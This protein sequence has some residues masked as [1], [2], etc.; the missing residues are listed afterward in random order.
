VLGE[1]AALA[2]GRATESDGGRLEL[3]HPE[4]TSSSDVSDPFIAAF[5][6]DLLELWRPAEQHPSAALG[7]RPFF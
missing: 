5:E 2:C 4:T 6:H 3:G 7:A 1:P